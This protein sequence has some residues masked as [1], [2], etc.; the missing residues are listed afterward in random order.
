ML[1]PIAQQV[2]ATGECATLKSPPD[3]APYDPNDLEDWEPTA[4]GEC[5]VYGFPEGKKVFSDMPAEATSAF[6]FEASRKPPGLAGG[7]SV[8]RW[9][10]VDWKV[11]EVRERRY[12]GKISGFT[13]FL[14]T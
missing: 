1:S 4:D 2:K 7:A 6:T 10:D 11:L 8:L 13:L 12:L 3:V 14:A 9:N 5:T